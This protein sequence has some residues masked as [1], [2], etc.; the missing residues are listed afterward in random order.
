[1]ADMCLIKTYESQRFSHIWNELENGTILG[2]STNI[3]P[4]TISKAYN[5]LCKYN[6]T[7]KIVCLP[8]NRVNVSFHQRGDWNQT[9]PPV[10]VAD[11]VLH[12][13]FMC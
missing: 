2:E 1:M 12:R 6:K 5:V 8:R 3:H 4:K 11:G 9:S 10:A 7:S 13:Y